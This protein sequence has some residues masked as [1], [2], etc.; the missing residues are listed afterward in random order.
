MESRDAQYLM[1]FPQTQ[2]PGGS[3]DDPRLCEI[4]ST[5][6]IWSPAAGGENMTVYV[7]A[8]DGVCP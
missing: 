2:I 3:P 1:A 7:L 4:F 8:W 6:G 5:G